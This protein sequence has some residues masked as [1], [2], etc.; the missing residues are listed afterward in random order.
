[1]LIFENS[2]E[3]LMEYMSIKLNSSKIP[4][5]TKVSERFAMGTDSLSKQK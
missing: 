2:K 3:K 4:D 1:M 5:K